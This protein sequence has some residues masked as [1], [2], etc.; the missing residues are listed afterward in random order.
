MTK[1]IQ[2]EYIPGLNN[3]SEEILR[4]FRKRLK[5]GWYMVTY[6][7]VSLD[8]STVCGVK[9]NRKGELKY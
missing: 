5:K 7:G 9:R 8:K 4:V 2:L 6:R 1:R 3:G